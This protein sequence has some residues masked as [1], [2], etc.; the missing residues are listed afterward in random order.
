MIILPFAEM[1]RDLEAVQC[2][3]ATLALHARAPRAVS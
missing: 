3:L 2:L 1:R